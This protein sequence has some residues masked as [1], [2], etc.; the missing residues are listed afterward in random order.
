MRSI[1]VIAL[2]AAGLCACATEGQRE[3]ASLQCQA[4]GITQKDPQFDLCMRSYTLQSNQDSLE[5]SYHRALNPT[6]D[7]RMAH[8]WHGY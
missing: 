1:L 7:R 3:A 4:V 5:V 8:T 2:A 6:Y